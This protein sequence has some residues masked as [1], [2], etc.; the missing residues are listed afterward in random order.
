LRV[1]R[2]LGVEV[3]PPLIPVVHLSDRLLDVVIDVLLEL[4]LGLPEVLVAGLRRCPPLLTRAQVLVLRLGLDRGSRTHG[5]P[6]VRGGTQG[7]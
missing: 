4:S 7:G 2:I 5:G 6:A 1:V 3:V